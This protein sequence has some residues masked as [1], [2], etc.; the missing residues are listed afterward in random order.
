M[1]DLQQNLRDA[2]LHASVEAMSEAE[3]HIRAALKLLDAAPRD[4]LSR[5]VRSYIGEAGFAITQ[6]NSR[7]AV[8]A[9]DEA[10][11]ALDEE[12]DAGYPE[13]EGER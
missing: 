5:T 2:R 1:R 13:T 8:S 6:G 3:R 4:M 7:L 12:S 10:L 9:I 11:E